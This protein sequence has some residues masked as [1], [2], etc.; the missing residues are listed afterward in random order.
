MKSRIPLA[1]DY[2]TRDGSSNKDARIKNAFVEGTAQ[3]SAVIKRPAI[4]TALATASGTA[5][6]GIANNSLVYVIN[7]DS[8]R[9]YNY[10]GTLQATIAL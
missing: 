2:I 6:G 5:Q 9:S 3:D 1:T 8:L 10:A 7:G 4:N